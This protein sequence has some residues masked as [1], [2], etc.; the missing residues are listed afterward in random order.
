MIYKKILMLMLT[1]CA[2]TYGHNAFAQGGGLTSLSGTQIFEGLNNGT[3]SL[4]DAANSIAVQTNTSLTQTQDILLGLGG[5]SNNIVVTGQ[6]LDQFRQGN[7]SSS[8]A[9]SVSRV[10]NLGTITTP[11]ALE[12]ALTSGPVL[13]EMQ[14]ILASSGATAMNQVVSSVTNVLGGEDAI[15]QLLTPALNTTLTNAFGSLNTELAEAFSNVTSVIGSVSAF[16][17]DLPDLTMTQ[18]LDSSIAGVLP[19]DDL[20]QGLSDGS[21][22]PLAQAEDIV[23]NLVGSAGANLAQA[24]QLLSFVQGGQLSADVAQVLSSIPNIGNITNIASITSILSS[25]SVTDALQASLLAGGVG[26]FNQALSSITNVLGGSEALQQLS[27]QVGSIT[28]ALTAANASLAGAFGGLS[29]LQAQLTTLGTDFLGQLSN[30]QLVES[31]QAGLLPLTDIANQIATN[32]GEPLADVQTLL[33]NFDLGS[34]NFA[35]AGQLINQVATGVISGPIAGVLSALPDLGNLPAIGDISSVLTSSGI[36]TAL[37]DILASEGIAAVQNAIAGITSIVGG[38]AG[39]VNGAT[40]AGAAAIA[41]AIASAAP[42]IAAAFGG[43]AALAGA[44]GSAFSGVLS[45][46]LGSIV[47][48]CTSKCDKGGNVQPGVPGASCGSACV[49]CNTCRAPIKSN[50]KSIRKFVTDQFKSHQQ[51]FVN[52]IIRDNVLPALAR[53]TT[54]FSII[55]MQQTDIIGRFFDA[56]HQLETQRLLQAMSAETYSNFTP[57]KALCEIG[58]MKRSL[59]AS[60][61]KSDLAKT[62]IAQRSLDRFLRSGDVLSY[63]SSISDKISRRNNFI[64]K[65]CN[66]KDNGNGLAGLCSQTALDDH[67]TK[68]TNTQSALA[69]ET[70]PIIRTAIQSSLDALNADTP[71]VESGARE[72]MNKDVNYVAGFDVPQTL[73]IDFSQAE[74]ANVTPDEED[75]FALSAN[76]YAHN[77]LPAIGDRVLADG[78]GV[79]KQAAYTYLNYRSLAA[80]RSVAHTSFAT[81]AGFKAEG[82]PEAA[83]YLKNI[84]QDLG[85]PASEMDNVFGENPSYKR[86]LGTLASDLYKRNSFYTELIDKPANARRKGVAMRGINLMLEREIYNS[87]LRTQVIFGL[88]L[89]AML[90]EEQDNVAARIGS[91]DASIDPVDR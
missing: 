86:Q 33:T 89:D 14:R 78:N 46:G 88:A 37:N 13:S 64:K 5:T 84:A 69:A 43:T 55:A 62:V 81:I 63:G 38:V 77:V 7:F 6:F 29:N 21:S 17:E 67:N 1:L 83:P 73:K 19:V 60:S 52:V 42:G 59:V 72:R 85:V 23:N 54:Q 48:S 61:R 58:T 2:L 56:K 41:N 26:A 87:A 18:L 3:I 80:K 36:T 70:N 57:P 47:G 79:P 76:L 82:D 44:I 51:W 27:S 75:V 28:S 10:S 65:Y 25:S 71:N 74:A 20:I 4:S 15:A 49:T 31:L 16:V 90:Q 12:A 66:K 35:Q 22:I 8:L 91:I 11:A 45:S 50:H 68:I 53:M 24:G 39:I 34:I 40:A 9:D 32:L 30:T